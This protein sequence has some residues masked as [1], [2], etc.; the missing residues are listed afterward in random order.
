MSLSFECLSVNTLITDVVKIFVKP[1]RGMG[2]VEVE[3]S[4]GWLF[5]IGCRAVVELIHKNRIKG[6]EIT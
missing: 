4:I 1:E 3:K 2:P 6:F 5:K